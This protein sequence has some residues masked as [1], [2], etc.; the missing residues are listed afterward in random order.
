LTVVLS[1]PVTTPLV[2]VVER[3]YRIARKQQVDGF[4]GGVQ[5]RESLTVA[6][7]P[8]ECPTMI[9]GVASRR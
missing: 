2:K 1:W 9:N 8:F 4:P 6:A 3:R 7:P 5:T